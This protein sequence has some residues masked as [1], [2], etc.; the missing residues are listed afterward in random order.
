[1][2]GNKQNRPIV[3][4]ARETGVGGEEKSSQ[5]QHL[6]YRCSSQVYFCRLHRLP[7]ALSDGQLLCCLTRKDKKEGKGE[8]GR[9]LACELFSPLGVLSLGD[10]SF[11]E[12]GM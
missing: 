8:V 10:E 4:D 1:M 9:E 2:R 6:K 3:D 11:S 7:G 12:A 5:P